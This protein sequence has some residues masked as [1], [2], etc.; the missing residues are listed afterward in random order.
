MYTHYL[1]APH[2]LIRPPACKSSSRPTDSQ[3]ERWILY[4]IQ[5]PANKLP[6]Q[7]ALCQEQRRRNPLPHR[8]MST[9]SIWSKIV[10]HL[11]Q[12]V[13]IHNNLFAPIHRWCRVTSSG[14]TN[15]M[16]NTLHSRELINTAWILYPT[17]NPTG[18]QILYILTWQFPRYC[19]YFIENNTNCFFCFYP[20]QIRPLSAPPFLHLS[21]AG[22]LSEGSTFT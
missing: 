10:L 6:A 3:T 18:S 13:T 20:H 14:I 21:G 4:I 12:N 17:R 8:T 22:M 2:P 16:R 11:I 9:F 15:A 7:T 1:T 19:V 5:T